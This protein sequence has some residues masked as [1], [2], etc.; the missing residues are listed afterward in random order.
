MTL[1]FGN[2]TQNFVEFNQVV[3]A[4]SPPEVIAAA[5]ESFRKSAALNASYLAYIGEFFLGTP[6]D[7]QTIDFPSHQVS[8]CLCARLSIC[9]FGLIPGRGM[10]RGFASIIFRRCYDK[11]F[12]ISTKLEPEKLRPVFRP[13]PVRPQQL[14]F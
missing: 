5:A 10:P 11:I 13:T 14:F 6:P 9:M 7:L 1:L 8:E 2:L 4:G 12:N 3:G